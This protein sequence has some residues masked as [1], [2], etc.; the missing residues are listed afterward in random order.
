[1][2]SP[3]DRSRKI[4]V[5]FRK[6]RGNRPRQVDLTRQDVDDLADLA[7]DERLSGKGDLTRHRTLVVDGANSE[8]REAHDADCLSGR[9]LWTVGANHSCVQ[10]DDGRTY[11][12]S[13]RRVMRTMERESRNLIAAG[14]RVV[15]RP[16]DGQ[17]GVIERIEPRHS[18]LSR[19]VA[20]SAHI[21]VANIDQ[22]AIVASASDP[23]LKP[24]L[25]DRFLVSCEVGGARGIVC[26]NKADTIQPAHLQPLIGQYARLGCE[27]ILTSATSGTGI[28]RLRQLLR[29]KATVLTGQSGV[30]KSSLLNA[31]QP[32]LGLRTATVSQDSGKGRHTTR[33]AELVPLECGG[34]VVD[35][36][37]IRQ[38]QLW[39]VEAE[40]VEAYFVEFRP[41]V[42]YCKFPNCS[43]TH[44]TGCAVL[45]AVSQGLISALRYESYT[46]IL[47]G[48]AE[49]DDEQ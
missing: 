34:W 21:I 40:E 19:G 44:E 20:R 49:K 46:R 1:M 41:F 17:T 42:A 25:I 30:G 43:H 13:V 2:N 39:A 9:V 45:S 15:F 31:I 10:T 29:G 5:Q 26:I 6:N 32:G 18:T 36:P 37:G 12:C 11:D 24:A 47:S 7:S 48:E 38:F 16:A 33:V 35:T 4:R 27:V 23:P 8:R 14:D 28:E 3:D 22:A